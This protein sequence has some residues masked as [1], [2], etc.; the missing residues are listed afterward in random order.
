MVNSKRV[1][2]NYDTANAIFYGNVNL[3]EDLDGCIDK[4]GHIHLKDKLGVYNEWNFP[5]LGKGNIDFNM[6]IDKL[7]K[8]NN[9]CPLSIEIEFT[10]DG[11]KD[12]DE[13]NQAVQDSYDYLRQLGLEI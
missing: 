9:S 13:V 8:A 6:V 7:N 1:L 2:I 4:I 10:K 3:E 12:V 5:A 11:A